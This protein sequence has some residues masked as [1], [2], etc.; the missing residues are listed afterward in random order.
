MEKFVVGKKL[1][2]RNKGWTFEDLAFYLLNPSERGEKGGEDELFRFRKISFTAD[3]VHLEAREKD[4]SVSFGCTARVTRDYVDEKY[5]ATLIERTYDFLGA[6]EL[7]Y[8]TLSVDVE[9]RLF[10]AWQTASQAW[11]SGERKQE[12]KRAFH[13]L[14]YWDGA[15]LLEKPMKITGTASYHVDAPEVEKPL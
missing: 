13:P 12:R 11:R 1:L 2:F 9:R 5:L 10:S 14:D 6:S 7:P 8:L 15:D 3:E 4:F